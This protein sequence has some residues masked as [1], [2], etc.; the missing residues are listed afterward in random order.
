MNDDSTERD[1]RSTPDRWLAW[2]GDAMFSFA[3]ARLR[4]RVLAEDAVQESLLA[5]LAA[6]GRFRGH[7]SE[8]SWLFGILKHKIIDQ[9]RRDARERALAGEGDADSSEES[10]FNPAGT[11]RE[12][13]LD[14]ADPT[15]D[16]E[17]EEFWIVLTHCLDGLPVGL[18]DAMRL[19]E[20]D[21]LDST[22][23]CKALGISSTN[24]WVRLHRARLR[25]RACIE[26]SWFSERR[27]KEPKR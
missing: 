16:L 20:I 24:L 9:F 1:V 10:F 19:I 14:W 3:L 26:H 4:N 18:A 6:R 17:R 2:Y 8:K 25:L 7:A 11:W 13:P 5:A 27:G 12:P 23:V 22:T 15:A 21:E